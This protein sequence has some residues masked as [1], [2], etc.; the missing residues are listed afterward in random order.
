MPLHWFDH[1][2]CDSCFGHVVFDPWFGYGVCDSWF[3]SGICVPW[4]EC[5]CYDV[6]GGGA[7]VLRARGWE[8]GETTCSWGGALVLR[9]DRGWGSY[10]HDVL[11]RQAVGFTTCL[12]EGQ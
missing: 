3:G 6:L 12:W 11:E 5:W 7:L 10:S 1:E 8:T 2:L 4:V 9:R